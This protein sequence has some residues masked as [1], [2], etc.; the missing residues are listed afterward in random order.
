MINTDF[1]AWWPIVNSDLSHLSAKDDAR[2]R[3]YNSRVDIIDIAPG[4]SVYIDGVLQ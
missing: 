4:S 1:E 2:V 3:M